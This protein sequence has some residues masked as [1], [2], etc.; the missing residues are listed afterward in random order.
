MTALF[1]RPLRSVVPL[2]GI[3]TRFNAVTNTVVSISDGFTLQNKG[4]RS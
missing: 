4:I 2:C 1:W 3:T